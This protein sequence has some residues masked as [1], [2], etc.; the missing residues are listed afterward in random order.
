MNILMMTNTF[1]PHVGGVA[2]SVQGFTDEFRRRGHR[3]VVVASPFETA[4]Y[5]K[6]RDG[7]DV[8]RV[9]AIQGFH[10]SGFSLPYPAPGFLSAALKGFRPDV[11]HVHH[12]FLLGSTGL[13]L[14][15]VHGAPVV[16][17]HHTLYEHYTRYL[18][19]DSDTLKRF[20][21]GLAS[22]FANL[23]DRVFA[24]S[25]S[26]AKLLRGRGVKTGIDVI[27]TGVDLP[28]WQGDGARWRRAHGIP[29]S[30]VLVGHVGRLAPEK[31]LRFLSR[32][33]SDF[34]KRRPDA[35]FVVA[36]EG[37]EKRM[38]EGIFRREGTLDRLLMLG[39]LSPDKLPDALGA[40]NA[41]AFSS[42]S[43]TQGMVVTEA[44]ACGT[45]V[46]AL[47]GPGVRDVVQDGV[48]GRL[49]PLGREAKKM[50]DLFSRALEDVAFAPPADRRLLRAAALRTAADCSMTRCA[51]QAL[52]SY[53]KLLGRRRRPV[54]GTW[55]S[56]SR[57]L[58]AH[59]TLFQ[60]AA[61]SAG[62]ALSGS[63]RPAG[64]P[65]AH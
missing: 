53:R 7:P 6:R 24:P 10:S 35:R 17:T 62:D 2:R 41:F 51:D 42:L 36:G 34:L 33:V 25:L 12:P 50:R 29:V 40:C 54:A 15:R 56:A 48:N 60:N 11:V 65:V 37:P 9:P 45:P 38:M 27:P 47:D 22:G 28:R 31:N 64:D 18:P 3:V 63:A 46:V 39:V 52:A 21:A 49:V 55:A 30:A 43:E 5:A 8:V 4:G 14:G 19:G 20:A 58:S 13:V 57:W 44:M 32:A 1:T 26:L 59:W 61:V 16:F 23:A